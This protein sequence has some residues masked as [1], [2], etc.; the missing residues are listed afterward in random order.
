[1][2][3]KS[4]AVFGVPSFLGSLEFPDDNPHCPV[5]I[6]PSFVWLSYYVEWPALRPVRGEELS[7]E[8]LVTTTDLWE[9]HNLNISFLGLKLD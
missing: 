1:M 4:A 2:P 7:P 6:L 5:V 3:Q 8:G 9:D